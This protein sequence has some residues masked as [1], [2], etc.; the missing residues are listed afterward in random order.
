MASPF[1]LQRFSL[2]GR[3]VLITGSSRGIGQALASGMAQAGA[4]VIVC[5]RDI[6]TLNAVCEHGA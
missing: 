6:T 3:R 2:Q 1:S 5:G 4:S